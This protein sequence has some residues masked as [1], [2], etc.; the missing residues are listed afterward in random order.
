MTIAGHEPGAHRRDIN[1]HR[2]LSTTSEHTHCPLEFAFE[3]P[4]RILPTIM[5]QLRG[6]HYSPKHLLPSGCQAR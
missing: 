3:A 6:P 4:A 5:L 1:R 2:V